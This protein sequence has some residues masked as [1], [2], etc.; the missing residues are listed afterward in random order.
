MSR[1]QATYTFVSS[2]VEGAYLVNSDT[3]SR[4]FVVQ[5][6]SAFEL[7]L[8]VESGLTRFS[9]YL[10]DPASGHMLVTKTKPCKSQCRLIESET[11][12]S[13]L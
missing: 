10:V 2:L 11:A 8:S 6:L 13:S 3:T 9:N 12:K 1:N 5:F 4:F 7:A